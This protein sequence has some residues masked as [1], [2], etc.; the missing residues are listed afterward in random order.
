[1]DRVEGPP[2]TT[3]QQ[4]AEPWRSSIER[5]ADQ[6][7][8][9]KALDTDHDH[10]SGGCTE[11]S[12]DHLVMAL[13]RCRLPHKP[14]QRQQH[15]E[16]TEAEAVE[17]GRSSVAEHRSHNKR[18]D[19]ADRPRDGILTEN[20]MGTSGEEL[21][22]DIGVDAT[23]NCGQQIHRGSQDWGW[24]TRPPAARPMSETLDE[25][26]RESDRKADGKDSPRRPQ[27]GSDNHSTRHETDSRIEP[28][29]HDHRVG[30]RRRASGG[31][32]NPRPPGWSS[33]RAGHGDMVSRLIP[34][35]ASGHGILAVTTDHPGGC[36]WTTFDLPC[37][38]LSTAATARG[39][40]PWRG[41]CRHA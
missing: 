10:R 14:D 22:M 19:G 4:C 37:V 1:M 7:S 26:Q 23:Q 34:D 6:N 2:C 8:R 41:N 24:P 30:T 25:P 11:R 29:D 15:E 40:A 35:C 32:V 28:A 17:L 21:G 31:G 27:G 5:L 33:G 3:G 12:G 20:P 38:S 16:Q 36:P 39:F 9:I 13:G 18:Q